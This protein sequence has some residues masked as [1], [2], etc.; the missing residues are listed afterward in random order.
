MEV[1][2]NSSDLI[3]ERAVLEEY[4]RHLD[5]I[6]TPKMARA[7]RLASILVL[8]NQG[9]PILPKALSA[10]FSITLVQVYDDLKRLR[11]IVPDLKPTSTIDLALRYL[12]TRYGEE[13]MA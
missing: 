7:K 4:E 13:E 8:Y 3:I 12:E 2:A 10:V 6:R 1:D 9:A 5:Q 11:E